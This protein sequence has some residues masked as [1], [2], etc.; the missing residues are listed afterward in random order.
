MKPFELSI[1]S[2]DIQFFMKQEHTL[3]QNFWL[4]A[5]KMKTEEV[6]FKCMMDVINLILY[7]EFIFNV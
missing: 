6:T 1:R 4:D 2:L 3:K 5:T 7:L